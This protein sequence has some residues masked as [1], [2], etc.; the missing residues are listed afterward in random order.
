MHVSRRLGHSSI[1]ITADVYSQ[2]TPEA[3]KTAATT[4]S[5]LHHRHLKGATMNHLHTLATRVLVR[6]KALTKGMRVTARR[7]WRA[8]LDSLENSPVYETVLLALIDLVLGHH[9]DLQQL[10]V[11]LIARLR[12]NPLLPDPDG[13]AY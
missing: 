13:W 3:A 11:R 10:L 9:L 12:R 2:V 5:Q 7:L 6:L 1:A 8:H 4:L